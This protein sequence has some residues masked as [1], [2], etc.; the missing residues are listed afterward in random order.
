MRMSDKYSRELAGV[1]IKMLSFKQYLKESTEEEGSFN[2]PEKS[3]E[4]FFRKQDITPELKKHFREI[5][6]KLSDETREHISSYNEDQSYINHALRFGEHKKM[7]K[8]S[9]SHLDSVTSHKTP[10]DMTVYRGGIPH[11]EVEKDATHKDEGFV[12]TTVSPHIAKKFAYEEDYHPKSN[13]P[14]IAKIHVPKGSMAHYTGFD[15]SDETFH[16]EKELLLRRGS[17][18]HVDK[19]VEHPDAHVVHMTLHH[20]DDIA[21][22]V[23]IKYKESVKRNSKEVP[24]YLKTAK[25]HDVSSMSHNDLI[26]YAAHNLGVWEKHN[27]KRPTSGH[28]GEYNKAHGELS[29][30]GLSNLDIHQAIEVKG[31]HYINPKWT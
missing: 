4:K 1:L 23:P 9:I 19:H 26:D 22:V 3:S 8:D 6:N 24:E 11:D 10:N 20:Q 16:Q 5:Q 31:K 30:R 17:H 18:F 25:Q 28:W 15:N 2:N 12:S 27:S 14:V 29:R 21:N 13:K 7:F